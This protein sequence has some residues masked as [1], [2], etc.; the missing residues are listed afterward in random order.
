VVYGGSRNS[1]ILFYLWRAE[2]DGRRP[3]QRLEIAGPHA[4]FPSISPV[5]NRLVFQRSLTDFDIWRY[6]IGGAAEPFL[7]SS[8][9]EDCPQYSPDGSRIAFESNRSGDVEE[10]WVTQADGSKPVQ[11]TNNLGRHQGSPRWSPDGRW[12]AFDSQGEDGVRHIYV[13]DG[14]GGR[15]RRISPEPLGEAVPSW[16]HDGK[17]IYFYTNR[18]GRDEIWRV[19][20]AGGVVEQVTKDGGHAGYE[21]PDGTTLFYLKNS[22]SPLF[23]KPISA[24][25]EPQVLDWVSARAFV[26]VDDGIYYIGRR[27]ADGRYP[28]Q[29]FQ[30]SSQTSRVLTNID[31]ALYLGLSVSPDRT[32][33]LFTKSVKSGANLMTIENFQ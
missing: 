28:L 19:P 4:Y 14:S 15:P 32:A 3:P 9:N 26:P 31:G 13:M 27:S 6:R 23:A 10:I 33:I 20:F 7:V 2:I 25:S 18:T 5:G 22:S 29:F 24:G 1:A 8:L 12:I 30:F 16:S 17:W 21:S 11:M